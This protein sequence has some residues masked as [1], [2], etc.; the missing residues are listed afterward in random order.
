MNRCKYKLLYLLN[1]VIL[2]ASCSPSLYEL[3]VDVRQ[4]ASVSIANIEDKSIAVYVAAEETSAE[5]DDA[6]LPIRFASGLAAGFEKNLGLEEGA[7]YVYNH[8]PE[9]GASP[10]V[11]DYIQSL[12]RQADSDMLI[13]VENVQVSDFTLMDN[14]AATSQSVQYMH[15]LFESNFSVYDGITAEQITQ[16]TIKD[17]V[18]LEVLS[19]NSTTRSSR[20]GGVEVAVNA[21][22]SRI[23]GDVADIFFTG[24]KRES[25]YLYVYNSLWRSAFNYARAFEWDRAIAVWTAE[26]TR[27]GGY[28][29][30]CAAINIAVGCEMTGRADLAL[31]WLNAAEKMYD[32]QELGLESYKLRLRQT[33]EKGKKN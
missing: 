26:L 33:I 6:S 14:I 17:T 3:A 23:G 11:M 9:R 25:R 31:E 18:Y 20:T 13:L 12:S 15:A 5:E 7:V 22:A 29:A 28:K 8:Y 4:P 16:K 19:N 27:N 21:I 30:A 10:Y 2:T 1:A 24:W 32:A